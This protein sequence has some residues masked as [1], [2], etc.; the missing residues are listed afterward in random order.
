M[1]GEKTEEP[2]AKKLRE[3][4]KK[5][6]VPKSRELGTAAVLL[7]VAGTL[8]GLGDYILAKLKSA[9]TLSLDAISGHIHAPPQTVMGAAAS[10]G[11]DAALPVL[12]AALLAG[13]LASFLQVGPLLAFEAVAPKLERVN[14]V[15]GAKNL[16]TQRKLIE[17]LKSLLKI[18]VVGYVAY[19][20]LA[21]GLGG[22]LGLAERDAEAELSAAAGLGQLLLIRVGAAVAAIAIVDV[23]YQRW[24]HRQDQKMTKDEVK[25]EHKDADG[26][27]QAKQ[28]RE[29][30]HREILEH[31][32]V[33]QVRLADVLVVNP[34]HVAVALRYDEEI[35]EAPEVLA[36]GQEH[37]ARRMI[38]AARQAGVPVLRDVPLARSLFE[39]ELGEEVPEKLYE[40]VAA[41]LRAAY[42]ER[43]ADEERQG[44]RT[45]P[46]DSGGPPTGALPA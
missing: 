38:E 3:A 13:A 32:T 24:R 5:G 36:K 7:A 9:L 17:L 28:Q 39:M 18:L 46:S 19:R 15:Q 8:T 25:R 33:E 26:D 27:P 31:N 37:L 14:P 40:A 10:L 30:L 6:Q 11:L 43:A 16:F 23:L 4:R 44:S 35:H 2:T 29:R 45:P 21:T 1:S 42:K 22:V 20:A 41:V 34:T 12:L